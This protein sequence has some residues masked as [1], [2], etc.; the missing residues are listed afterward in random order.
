MR[1]ILFGPPGSGKGTQANLLK[2]RLQLAHISTGDI[3][4]EAV[5]L[6][7]P[8]GKKAEP[9]MK[10]GQLVPDEMVN[11]MV[12]D[13]FR[14]S[15]R[16]EKFMMDGYP[17]TLAQARFFDDLLR[18]RGLD[19]TGVVFLEVNDD[20]IIRR[21]TGR[22]TCPKCQAPYHVQSKPPKK[23]GVCDVCGT[24]LVQR[25][26][27]KEE[28]VRQRLKV[29]RTSTADLAPYYRQR[30]LL[31]EVPGQGDIETIYKA[32]EKALK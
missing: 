3:L 27:D 25:A 12:A 1:I 11:E 14:R 30:G 23:P 21:L 8:T 26:D 24:A 31:H 18:Q 17:R 5:R 4:R 16:P 13:R 32:I 20:E 6:G 22:W 7:T 28:T 10:S 19:L 15:D 29:Y 9:I 2:E